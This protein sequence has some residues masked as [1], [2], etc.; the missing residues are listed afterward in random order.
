MKQNK[1]RKNSKPNPSSF[2]F[3]IIPLV[4]TYLLIKI[5]RILLRQTSLLLTSH[6]KYPKIFQIS[7]LSL[8]ESEEFSSWNRN[9]GLYELYN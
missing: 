5:T 3:F 8:L 2:R 9:D 6:L 4:Q 7:V 1:Q